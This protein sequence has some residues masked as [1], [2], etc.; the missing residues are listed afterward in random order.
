MRCLIFLKIT[1]TVVVR[2]P[3]VRSLVITSYVILLGGGSS[4]LCGVRVSSAAHYSHL[5]ALIFLYGGSMLYSSGAFVSERR[6]NKGSGSGR[7]S[8]TE[9]PPELKAPN[10]DR[11]EKKQQYS[12]Q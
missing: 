12:R 4:R 1:S 6:Y 5:N 7:R 3:K 8:R 11:E 2:S 9:K 10:K